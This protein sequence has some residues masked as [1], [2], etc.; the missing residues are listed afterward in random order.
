LGLAHHPFVI[1]PTPQLKKI[2]EQRHWPVYQPE[3]Q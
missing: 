3:A 2:A 1:N